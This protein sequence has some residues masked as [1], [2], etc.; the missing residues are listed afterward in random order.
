LIYFSFNF[1]LKNYSHK[2]EINGEIVLKQKATMIYEN[3]L[4]SQIAPGTQIDINHETQQ[5]LIK[6]VNRVIQG[7]HT[8][9]DMAIFDDVRNIL[10]KELL[11]YWAAYNAY[12][13]NASNEPPL[14]K[15]QKKLKERLEEFLSMKNLSPDD[16][17]LPDINLIRSANNKKTPLNSSSRFTGHHLS[18][19][20]FSITTGI[21]FRDERTM[22]REESVA[23]L[24][25]NV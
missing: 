13:K 14:S 24:S 19:I 20:V 12:S 5:K 18:N 1:T 8:S 25:E 22:M 10:L 9:Y 7:T 3:Y 16:F 23:Q 6:S 21:K 2:Q 17:K 11:P 15:Q 4:D